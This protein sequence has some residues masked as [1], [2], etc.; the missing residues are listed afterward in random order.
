MQDF[1]TVTVYKATETRSTTNQVVQR[2]GGEASALA[3]PQDR[4]RA[5]YR[6]L[7]EEQEVSVTRLG[8][9]LCV[10]VDFH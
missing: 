3:T 4:L 8:H 6:R 7:G 10:S 1:T 5:S 2:A 9:L